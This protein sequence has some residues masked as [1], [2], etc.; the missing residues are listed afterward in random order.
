MPKT[1]TG[2]F[3][4]IRAVLV[5]AI[6]KGQLPISLLFVIALILVCRIP[7]SELPKLANSFIHGLENYHLLGWILSAISAFG[8]VFTSRWQRRV[9]SEEMDRVADEKS[10]W[11]QENNSTKLSTTKTKARKK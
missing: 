10:H 11:Q 8:W 7:N 5:A 4:M 3:E 6:N 1:K 9:H 2:F